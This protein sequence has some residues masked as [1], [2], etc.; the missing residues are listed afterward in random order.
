MGKIINIIFE[1]KYLAVVEKPA[2]LPVYP[3]KGGKK[4]NLFNILRIKWP[5][6]EPAH[7]LDNDTSGLVIVAKTKEAF[8]WLKSQ[9][10]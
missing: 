1:D 4:D 6:A 8:Q 10:I 3:A 9:I 7:R 5:N 2:G